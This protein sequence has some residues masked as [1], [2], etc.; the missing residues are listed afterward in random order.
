[1]VTHHTV[2]EGTDRIHVGDR[3]VRVVPMRETINKWVE[4]EDKAFSGDNT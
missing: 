4:M 3:V 2:S 1:M